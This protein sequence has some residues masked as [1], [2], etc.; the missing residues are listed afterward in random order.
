MQFDFVE[1]EKEEEDETRNHLIQQ[2]V[3][4]PVSPCLQYIKNGR[5]VLDNI[6]CDLHTCMYTF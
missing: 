5:T 3:Q 6:R 4:H 2:R 1:E